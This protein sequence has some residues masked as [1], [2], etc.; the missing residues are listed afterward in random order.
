VA[1]ET[2]HTT[3]AA[4]GAVAGWLALLFLALQIGYSYDLYWL[5]TRD[6]EILVVAVAGLGITL[7]VI[8][9]HSE[10]SHQEKVTIGIVALVSFFV[11]WGVGGLMVSCANDNCL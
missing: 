7:L 3:L 11:I 2:K 6:F 9:W 5:L 4:A 1:L 8:F 10:A